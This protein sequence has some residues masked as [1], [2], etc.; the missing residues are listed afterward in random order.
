M[1]LYFKTK[2]YILLNYMLFLMITKRNSLPN[3]YRAI[4][5]LKH[6]LVNQ[7]SIKEILKMAALMRMYVYE[8]IL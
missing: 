4:G 8:G 2:G 7:Y 1:I 5:L 3:N 6:R